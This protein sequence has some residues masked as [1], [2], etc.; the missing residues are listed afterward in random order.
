MADSDNSTTPPRVTRRRLLG[1][2]AIAI[3]GWE[4]SALAGEAP[5]VALPYDPVLAIWREWHKIHKLGERL[6]DQS[7][8]LERTLVE[9]V[10]FPCA[11]VQLPGGEEVTVHSIRALR[12]VLGA[13][14]DAAEARATAEAH[15]AAHQARWDAADERTGYSHV[16]DAE[17]KAGDRAEELLQ[18]L[19]LTPAT[20]FAGVAAK[21]SA[22]LLE[23]DVR[24][25]GTEFPWPQIRSAFDDFIHVGQQLF[26]EVRFPSEM[27]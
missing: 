14:A 7:A 6:C 1:A 25:G 20:S 11:T 26:P 13:G 27:L 2:T 22:V 4:R 24:E 17:R 10:G 18:A 5:A 19:S 8:Y 21:L 15:F 12:E 23:S 16:A 9:I 3:V